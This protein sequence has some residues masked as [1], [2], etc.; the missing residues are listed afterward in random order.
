MAYHVSLYNIYSACL[1]WEGLRK[2]SFTGD[3]SGLFWLSE[4][5]AEN[6]AAVAFIISIV[7][8]LIF[9]IIKGSTGDQFLILQVCNSENKHRPLWSEAIVKTFPQ[10]QGKELG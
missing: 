8:S 5:P 6:S 9:F 1:L 2:Q 10:W 3:G 7:V 4:P